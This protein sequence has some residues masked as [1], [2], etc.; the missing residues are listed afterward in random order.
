[1]K[2]FY[3]SDLHLDF[4]THTCS[5]QKSVK[6]YKNLF[7]DIENPEDAVLV[8]AG[9]ISHYNIQSFYF[10]RDKAKMFKHVLVTSGNH[11]M[12]NISKK[13]E[14]K[15]TGLF[16]KICELKEYLKDIDNVTFLDGN[17]IVIDGIKFAGA[18]G[19]YDCSYF[20]KVQPSVYAASMITHWNSYSN[21]SNRIPEL[22]DP[23][24]LFKI[25]IE[26][27]KSAIRSLPDVMISHICPISEPLAFQTEFKNEK[28]SAYYSFNGLDLIEKYKPKYWIH[29]HMHN[30]SEFE[31]YDTTL[32]RNPA[33]Y[34]GE[35]DV[36]MMSFKVNPRAYQ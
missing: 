8:I 18:M 11:E 9:D 26:K 14:L 25:E 23:L 13:Q 21:D 10:I 34:P 2:V 32:V 35:N 20:Y 29:G 28:G 33:G 30:T 24:D 1:M 17:H 15:Y 7:K 12:Y 19:W 6:L 31:I 4:I 22:N 3:I 5:E 36:R 27:I 16:D